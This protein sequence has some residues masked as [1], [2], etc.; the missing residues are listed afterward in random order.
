VCVC[1]CVC[2]YVYVCVCVCVCVRAHRVRESGTTRTNLTHART[3]GSFKEYTGLCCGKD[4]ERPVESSASKSSS[5]KWRRYKTPA[6]PSKI[7]TAAG[8][9][10]NGTC[11]PTKSEGANAAGS[12]VSSPPAFHPVNIR[13]FRTFLLHLQIYTCRA[14]L[15]KMQGSLAE[16]TGI[17]ANVVASS[18]VSRPPTFHPANIQIYRAL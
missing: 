14:L 11:C 12:R 9:R 3:Q 13:I 5:R 6:Y 1:V 2:V 15:S 17:G 10:C 4:R 7:S 18:R 8:S 16:Y